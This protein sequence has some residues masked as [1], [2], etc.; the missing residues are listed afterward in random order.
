MGRG[1]TSSRIH[2]SMAVKLTVLRFSADTKSMTKGPRRRL[3]TQENIKTTKRR[4]LL[5]AAKIKRRRRTT[6]ARMRQ[7]WTPAKSWLHRSTF[8][9]KLCSIWAF[10]RTKRSILANLTSGS[11]LTTQNC[12]PIRPQQ[13]NPRRK[14]A[15]PERKV[16]KCSVTSEP[17]RRHSRSSWRTLR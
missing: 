11:R 5:L 9:G 6:S 16:L 8:K 15:S 2:L 14:T 17:T 3:S 1:R 4:T 12:P 10:T 7:H 13:T